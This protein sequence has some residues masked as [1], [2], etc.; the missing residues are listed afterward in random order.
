MSYTFRGIVLPDELKA[1]LDAYIEDGRPTGGFLEACICN[2]LREA[3]SR[4][5]ETSVIALRAI[6]A[7]LYLI[8]PSCCWGRADSFKNWIETK[9]KE[10]EDAS[11]NH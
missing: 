11:I 9:R 7:Y 6:V 1:S 8:A 5:D 3:F 4:A 10:R 2:N